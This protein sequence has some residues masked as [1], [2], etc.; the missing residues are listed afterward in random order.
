MK[1]LQVTRV[2]KE[3]GDKR[4]MKEDIAAIS[5]SIKRIEACIELNS[6]D[7]HDIKN[8]HLAHIEPSLERMDIALNG[9][10]CEPEKGLVFQLNILNK[11]FK[12]LK[13]AVGFGLSVI[14]IVIALVQVNS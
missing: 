7:I 6:K 8:N 2:N 3:T 4:T 1:T 14:A 11:E 12:L 10:D 9:T 13:W 5:D